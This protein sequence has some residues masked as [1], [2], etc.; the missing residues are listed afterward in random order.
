MQKPFREIRL[1]EHIDLPSVR[2]RACPC[3]DPLTI[4]NIYVYNHDSGY[5]GS[6]NTPASFL[7]S[8]WSC[9]NTCWTAFG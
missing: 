8:H 7:H 9:A 4:Y 5:S 1:S 6:R 3:Y 2:L